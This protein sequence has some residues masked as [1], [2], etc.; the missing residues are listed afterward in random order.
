MNLYVFR[1]ATTSR[2][3]LAFCEL[4]DLPVTIK[5]V[6]ILHGEHHAPP[7]AT[8]NPSRLVP[9]LDDDGFVLTQA[10]AILRYLATKS[11]AAAAL[12]PEDRRARARVDEVIAWL[13]ADFN[14]DFGFQYVYPQVFAHHRRG[15]DEATQQT[16][17]W[18][19]TKSRA[20]LAVLDQHFL[21]GGRSFLVGDAITI[22]DLLGASVVSLGELVGCDLASY[23]NVRRW[24]RGVTGLP[25]WKQIDGAFQGFVASLDDHAFV[26]LS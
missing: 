6:D 24:Y 3:V 17:E 15:S 9:V 8:L 20:W 16:I 18:G 7:F 21:S 22:A 13:E 19:R 10:S 5:D 25:A 2:A 26:G 23:P 4:T 14:K 12:Y 11:P 1:G